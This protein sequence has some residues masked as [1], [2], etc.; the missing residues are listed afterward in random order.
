LDRAGGDIAGGGDFLSSCFAFCVK[1][2]LPPGIFGLDARV[3]CSLVCI[4]TALGH[5]CISFI[6]CV[7]NRDY[8]NSQKAAQKEQYL[9]TGRASKHALIC[10]LPYRKSLRESGG[11]ACMRSDGHYTDAPARIVLLFLW[12]ISCSESAPDCTMQRHATNDD[13]RHGA[14]AFTYRNSSSTRRTW[15]HYKR[16]TK[17]ICR[18]ELSSS[19]CIWRQD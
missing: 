8:C 18:E 17:M 14:Q 9:T 13:T 3:L 16:A 1:T 10:V 19:K 7:S 12:S 2:R 15:R 4:P 11:L 6:L 5:F